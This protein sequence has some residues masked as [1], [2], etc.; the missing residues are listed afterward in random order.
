M[1]QIFL[2][3]WFSAM[4]LPMLW[5]CGSFRCCGSFRWCGSFRC[6]GSFRS[7]LKDVK[8]S[9]RPFLACCLRPGCC[10]FPPLCL[11]LRGGSYRPLSWRSQCPSC[12]G[13]IPS[14]CKWIIHWYVFEVFNCLS[15]VEI[16][17]CCFYFLTSSPS[18]QRTCWRAFRLW[19]EVECMLA[20]RHSGYY[21]TMFLWRSWVFLY[22]LPHSPFSSHMYSVPSI[23]SYVYS[24]SMDNYSWQVI[25]R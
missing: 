4:I 22:S 10:S 17:L 20:G 15:S 3:M 19:A 5:W 6:C 25:A 2:M 24:S 11:S 1:M 8:P 9:C 14:V 16:F 12:L 21:R 13:I 23:H 18:A 7:S